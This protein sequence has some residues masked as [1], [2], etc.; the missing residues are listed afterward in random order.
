M[1]QERVTL[2]PCCKSLLTTIHLCS[3]QFIILAIL[4]THMH[5]Y[6]WHMDRHLHGSDHDALTLIP[7]S[8]ISY[9]VVRSSCAGSAAES[10]AVTGCDS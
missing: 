9:G 7:L 8:E 10:G 3:F 4:A 2:K 1:F 5:L 6:L